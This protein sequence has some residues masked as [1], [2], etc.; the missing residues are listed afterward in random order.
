MSD[1]LTSEPQ[2]D[3]V[4][5]CEEWV[6]SACAGEPFYRDLEG[7]RYCV[8]HFPSKEK[9]ADFQQALQRKLESEDFDFR[10][11]WFPD[12]LSFRDY[13]FGTLAD[14]RGA[15]FSDWA[16]FGRATFRGDAHFF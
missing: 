13:E 5:D 3:F 2:S 15:T 11:V 14:F 7:K 10:G 8:L 9:S 1:S 16:D 6:R 4:C 12:E